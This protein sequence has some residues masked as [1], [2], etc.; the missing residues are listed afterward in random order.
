[1]SEY[2]VSH[3]YA[4]SLLDTAVEKNI[5]NNVAADVELVNTVLRSSRPLAM[6]MSSPVVKPNIKLAI[7]KDLFTSRVNPETMNFLKFVIHKDRENLLESIT[8]IFLQLRDN[9]LGI[10]NVKVKSAVEFSGEQKEQFKNNLEKY[11]RKN[12]RLHFEIDQS[13]IGGFVAQVE[14]TVFDASIQH[15]L[16]LLK[17]QLLKGSV[18]LN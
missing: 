17:K 14:D 16:E 4:S 7:L 15:Q 18:S 1:M 13:I 8:E 12:V 5:L 11:L 3:R 9:K 6:A 2:K 10:V